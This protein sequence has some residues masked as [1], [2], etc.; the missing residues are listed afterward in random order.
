MYGSL[1][2]GLGTPGDNL[3]PYH[4]SSCELGSLL[5]I[6]HPG[7]YSNSFKTLKRKK[8]SC[9]SQNMAGARRPPKWHWEQAT[10]RACCPTAGLG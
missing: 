10:G 5:Q 8:G 4:P 2:L 9:T 3:S 1:T 7:R 6:G